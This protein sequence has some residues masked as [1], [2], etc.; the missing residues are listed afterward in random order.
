MRWSDLDLDNALLRVNSA[1][2]RID[3]AFRLVEPKTAKSRRT[4]H[5]PK[6]VVATLKAQRTRQTEERL[7]AGPH[8]QNTWDLV[9][10][11]AIGTP[12]DAGTVTHSFQKFLVRA[13]IPRLLLKLLSNDK[14]KTRG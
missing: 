5:L 9:F 7:R 2:Q 4:L 10:T 12:L 8:W 13:G 1:L 11:T 14:T 3:G 6:A